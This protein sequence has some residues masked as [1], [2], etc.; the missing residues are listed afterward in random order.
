MGLVRHS[1][2]LLVATFFAVAA[3]IL[4][5]G[6]ARKLIGQTTSGDVLWGAPGSPSTDSNH[7]FWWDGVNHRLGLGTSSPRF[8]LDIVDDGDYATRGVLQNAGTG[9]STYANWAASNG[10]GSGPSYA[11][12]G[13]GGV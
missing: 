6:A 3:L 13:V 12:F 1:V 2:T 8:Q 7:E 10:T 11:V 5:P 4:W 9:T